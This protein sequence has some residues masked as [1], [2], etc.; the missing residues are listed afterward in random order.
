MAIRTDFAEGAFAPSHRADMAEAL[1]SQSGARID[2]N[3]RRGRAA[4]LN[5][6]GRFEALERTRTDDGWD[7]PEEL[8]PFKT[9]VQ[10][11]KPRT[12]LTRNESPDI[13]FDRSVNPYRGCEHGCIYCFARPSHSYM[14]LSAGLDFEAKLFAKPDIAKL[15]DASFP[16]PATS[17]GRSPLAPTPIPI[18]PSRRIGGSCARFLKCWRPRVIR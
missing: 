2:V 4:A 16:N 7:I 15:L 14:G 10:I 17:R 18:S 12:A 5:M 3:R 8:P 1:A 6:A 9:E 11:E 13:P